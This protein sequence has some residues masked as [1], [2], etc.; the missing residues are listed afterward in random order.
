MDWRGKLKIGSFVV[1]GES[2]GVELPCAS[3]VSVRIFASSLD[4]RSTPDATDAVG[5]GEDGTALSGDSTAAADSF[6]SCSSDWFVSSSEP[7]VEDEEDDAE[8]DVE[9]VLEDVVEMV[10]P[11]ES[12]DDGDDADDDDSEDDTASGP[13][14]DVEASS[15]SSGKVGDEGICFLRSSKSRELTPLDSLPTGDS[16]VLMLLR[17]PMLTGEIGDSSPKPSRRSPTPDIGTAILRAIIGSSQICERTD[18]IC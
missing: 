10:D 8:E 1:R 14:A 2:N 13:E 9:Q 16:G 5:E 7:D 15:F 18:G 11:A 3:S 17:K 4:S 6:G 12:E